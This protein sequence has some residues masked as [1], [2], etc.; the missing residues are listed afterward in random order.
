ML[1]IFFILLYNCQNS[2]KKYHPRQ[3]TTKQEIIVSSQPDVT[4]ILI[5]SVFEDISNDYPMMFI[6]NSGALWQENCDPST[7]Q[8]DTTLVKK[9]YDFLGSKA[10]ISIGTK[11]IQSQ[12][13][14]KPYCMSGECGNSQI[15]FNLLNHE[16]LGV[17]VAKDFLLKNDTL[18][19]LQ[20]F[21]PL[22]LKN[23]ITRPKEIDSNQTNVFYSDT[24]QE[25]LIQLTANEVIQENDWPFF[26]NLRWRFIKWTANGW[27]FYKFQN[28]NF[29]STN[30]PKP[31]AIVFNKIETRIIWYEEEGIC[32][33]S[34]S[35]I[36]I[37]RIK[38]DST[39][40]ITFEDSK[41]FP[42]GIGQPCD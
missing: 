36:W 17:L 9:V 8:I 5:D 23:E 39:N 37:S 7:Y 40:K 28:I 1:F 13:I 19:F 35:Y 14:V 21:N 4:T 12:K 22:E 41:T 27:R 33:P 18:E 10:L 15:A 38:K 3:D 29:T 30:L 34:Y 16:C 26:S 32:C 25:F 24:T 11:G 2:D 31:L 6:E 20:I 42:G